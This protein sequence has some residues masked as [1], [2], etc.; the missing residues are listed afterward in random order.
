MFRSILCLSP[1]FHR[2]HTI[3][4]Y[5]FFTLSMMLSLFCLK[6]Q[7]AIICFPLLFPIGGLTSNVYSICGRRSLFA[8]R[9]KLQFVWLSNYLSICQCILAYHCCYQGH[10]L[11]DI[12][13]PVDVWMRSLNILNLHWRR[14]CCCLSSDDGCHYSKCAICCEANLFYCRVAFL[15]LWF[16]TLWSP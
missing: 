1:A 5:I 2:A 11:T 14:Y 13:G 12:S 16:M 6:D 15:F 7:I 10:C 8:L 4:L 3:W 9:Y